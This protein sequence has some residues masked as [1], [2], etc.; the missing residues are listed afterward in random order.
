LCQSLRAPILV[1]RTGQIH[2]KSFKHR[3]SWVEVRILELGAIFACGVQAWAVMSNHLQIVVH[4]SP[5]TA[6]SWS[7]EEIATRWVRLYPARNTELCAQKIAAILENPE[8]V[9]E[10]RTRLA[11]LSWL[12]KSLSEP[13]ARKVRCRLG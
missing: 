12:M 9:A 2:G 7:P 13:I 3:K 11:N 8:I 4:M 5:A 6:N 1:V 10:Y